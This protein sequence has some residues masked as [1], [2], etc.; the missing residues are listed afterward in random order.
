MSKN[1]EKVVRNGWKL[2]KFE[3]AQISKFTKF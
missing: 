3:I 1:D 2:K